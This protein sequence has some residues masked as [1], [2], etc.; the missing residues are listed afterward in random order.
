MARIGAVISLIPAGSGSSACWTGPQTANGTP[1]AAS[2]AVS[3]ASSAA[4]R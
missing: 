2:R 3:A 4:N 1:S